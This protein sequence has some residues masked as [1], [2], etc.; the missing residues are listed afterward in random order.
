VVAGPDLR[1]AGGPGP[2]PPT[3]RGLPTKSLNF[4]AKMI[5]V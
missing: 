1:G 5:D 2:R 4:L 3:N